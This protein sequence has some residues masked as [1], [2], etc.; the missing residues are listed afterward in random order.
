MGK[1]TI[2]QPT[3]KQLEPKSQAAMDLLKE[4]KRVLHKVYREFSRRKYMKYKLQFPRLRESELINK[5]I[6]EWESLTEADKMA[7]KKEF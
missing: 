3:E 2:K 5:V 6:K 1:K 4:K 7:L